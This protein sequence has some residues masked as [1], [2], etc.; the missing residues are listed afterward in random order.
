MVITLSGSL[1]FRTD[2]AVLLPA[3]QTRLGQVTD[4]LMSTADRTIIVEGHTDSQ[5]SDAHNLDLAQR[6][7]EA[8]RT[9]MAQRGYDSTRIRAVGIGEA[10]PI[11]DN[12]TPEGR[13]NNRRVEVI[14]EPATTA[15]Q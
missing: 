11:A 1:L 13:A 3:A 7:A 14:V 12:A 4:A 15:S 5:G 8:V 2:E 6:R 9:F 10:R